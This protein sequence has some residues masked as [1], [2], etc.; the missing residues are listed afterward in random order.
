MLEHFFFNLFLLFLCIVGD[1]LIC[2]P[3]HNEECLIKEVK[4]TNIWMDLVHNGGGGGFGLSPLFMFFK[5]F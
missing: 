5:N 1:I 3:K 2:E 4:Q